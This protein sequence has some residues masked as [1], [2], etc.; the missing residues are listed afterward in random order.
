MAPSASSLQFR[1]LGRPVPMARARI[2]ADFGNFTPESTA[3]F[4][5]KVGEYAAAAAMIA[6]WRRPTAGEAVAVVVRVSP[7]LTKAGRCPK[8]RARGDLDNHVKAALDGM[9]E[10][11][12]DDD[13]S[14]ERIEAEFVPASKD[15][16]LD[17]QVRLLPVICQ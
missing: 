15:G 9:T 2:S 17:V 10:V 8:P 16:Y 6:R 12:F 13:A 4:R 5:E 3:D 14:V 11:L 7:Q 1:V